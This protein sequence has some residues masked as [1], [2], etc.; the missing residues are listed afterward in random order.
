MFFASLKALYFGIWQELE[1]VVEEPAS[2]PTMMRFLDATTRGVKPSQL[3]CVKGLWSEKKL[4]DRV[5]GL[6]PR[7][8][9]HRVS[10]VGLFERRRA[11]HLVS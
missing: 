1:L 3:V 7:Q 8:H 6:V 10:R 5:Y 9:K 2:A 11:L 4:N